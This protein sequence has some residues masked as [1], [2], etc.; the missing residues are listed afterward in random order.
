MQGNAS[1]EQCMCI[2][3]YCMVKHADSLSIRACTPH[4]GIAID[5]KVFH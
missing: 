1:V 4:A 5:Y 2:I 3:I